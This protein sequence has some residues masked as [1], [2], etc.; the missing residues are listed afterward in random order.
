[1]GLY[2]GFL[3]VLLYAGKWIK[4]KQLNL[5]FL[6]TVLLPCWLIIEPETTDNSAP[7]WFREMPVYV[8]E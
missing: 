5:H 7:G 1:M 3:P 4:K 6:A 2:G 8:R